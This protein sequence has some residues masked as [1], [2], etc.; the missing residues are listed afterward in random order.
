MSDWKQR[1]DEV[2]SFSESILK[3]AGLNKAEFLY[4]KKNPFLKGLKEVC[5]C[6]KE[7]CN[8]SVTIVGDYD[9]DGITASLIIRLIIVILTGQEP[10]IRIPKRFSEGYGLSEKI[11]DE[12]DSGLVITVDN[13]IAAI[14]AIRKAK[15]KGLTV[16]VT[17]HHL[18]RDDGEL[19]EADALMDPNAESESEFKDY[20]GAGLAYR[21]FLELCPNHALTQQAVALAAIGTVADVMPLLHDNRNIVIE[22]LT[23]MRQKR[24]TLGLTLL[25]EKLNLAAPIASDIGF[26]I[27]PVINASGRLYDDGPMDVIR[28]LAEDATWFD[29]NF[30]QRKTAAYV[31]AEELIH[32]NEVRKAT[33]E[34]ALHVVEDTVGDEDLPVVVC[35]DGISEGIVGL[36]AGKLVEQYQCPSLVFTN[37]ET[38]GILKGSGRSCGTFNLKCLLD[39]CKSVF[40]TYGGHAGAAG[41]TV[42]KDRYE[43]MK[44]ALQAAIREIG[45]Q[46]PDPETQ[47]YDWVIKTYQVVDMLRE[48]ETYAPYGEGNPE[49][50]FMISGFRAESMG[51]DKKYRIMGEK[52][53][54]LKM[55]SGNV[56]AIFFNKVVAWEAMGK[57]TELDLLGKLSWNEFKG[58]KTP[59]IEVLDFRP[60]TK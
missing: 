48:Q 43:E 33:V 49:P 8:Q 19:P 13:G 28:L 34:T 3:R 1:L 60:I 7:H 41:M 46:K 56:E 50:I 52:K 58:R 16:V 21:M 36:I 57:P 6:I 29:Q 54:V 10:T 23:K 32:R 12:I 22:G 37:G 40:V 44:E 26:K 31:L 11:I 59:Q 30:A 5:E 51:D 39:K 4:P 27:G 15:K 17:D 45:Y 47:Y 25:L 42:E 53:N 24:L 35:Q 38:D 2:K 9:A 14:E 18:P 20:C 55:R